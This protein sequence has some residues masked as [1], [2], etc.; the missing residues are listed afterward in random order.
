MNA[1]RTS[2]IGFATLL[3]L[4]CCVDAQVANFD[5]VADGTAIG[6]HYA[7][8][9]FSCAGAHCASP[10]VFARQITSPFSVPNIV[11][12]TPTGGAAVHN[13]TTGTIQ[14]AIACTSHTVSVQGRSSQVPEP[15]NRQQFAILVGL[16]SAGAAVGQAKGTQ[17]GQFELLTVS[18]PQKAIATLRLGVEGD[19][20]A[21]V[22]EFD[23]LN[24]E[25]SPSFRKPVWVLSG[26]ALLIL[27]ALYWWWRTHHP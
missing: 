15:L 25:C 18:D 11:S 9:T 8:L 23:N 19:G 6:T 3:T 17:F 5:D 21:G 4:A 13:P 24:V 2:W 10:D 14:V 27:G 16:D 1:C 7:G 22:A 20:V 12:P 26:A